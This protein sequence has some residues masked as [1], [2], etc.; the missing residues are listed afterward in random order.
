MQAFSLV[1][2]CLPL[3]KNAPPPASGRNAIRPRVAVNVLFIATSTGIGGIAALPSDSLKIA[4]PS[5]RHDGDF[6]HTI[7]GDGKHLAD[8]IKD[9]GA[10]FGKKYPL[11]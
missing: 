3:K 11:C 10:L 8:G 7:A 9:D 1:N 6:H 2:D 5:H 4:A